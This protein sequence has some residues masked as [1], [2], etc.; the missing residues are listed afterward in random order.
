MQRSSFSILVLTFCVFV[1]AG[2]TGA[3]GPENSFFSLQPLSPIRESTP[4]QA[5]TLLLMVQNG[6]GQSLHLTPGV[7]LPAGWRLVLPPPHLDLAAGATQ[8]VFLNVS[9]PPSTPP[10]D[11]RVRVSYTADEPALPARETE[12]VVRVLPVAGLQLMLSDAPAFTLA[13]PFDATFSV[14]NS[15]NTTLKL[16]FEVEV[17]PR[18]PHTVSQE[19]L[20]LAAGA[21]ATVTVSV[22]PPAGWSQA[23]TVY[24]RLIA[25]SQTDPQVWA[26]ATASVEVI[27]GVIPAR[28]AYYTLPAVMELSAS[29][30]AKE[31]ALA[32][33]FALRGSGRAAG[34]TPV[35]LAFDLGDERQ[36]VRL[37]DDAYSLSLG[38]QTSFL[39]PLVG[40]PTSGAGVGLQATVGPVT[41]GL[42]ILKPGDGRSSGDESGREQAPR[43]DSRLTLRA[44]PH[45]DLSLNSSWLMTGSGQWSIEPHLQLADG[46]WVEWEYGHEFALGT[47]PPGAQRMELGYSGAALSARLQWQH[48]EAGYRGEEAASELWSIQAS[49]IFPGVSASASLTEERD[50]DRPGEKRNLSATLALSG[51]KEGGIWTLT[52]MR[53]QEKD[54]SVPKDEQSDTM[55]YTVGRNLVQG[56]I[57][58]SL[59]GKQV[60]NGITSE[61]LRS[62]QCD[63][64]Y[65]VPI[66]RGRITPYFGVETVLNGDE[67]PKLSFGL[68]LA[69]RLSNDLSVVIS[70]SV[71]DLFQGAAR[72]YGGLEYQLGQGRYVTVN[73]WY[74]WG[75]AGNDY[76]LKAGLG[77]PFEVPLGR[78]PD[79]GEVRGRIVDESGTGIP[80]LVVEINNGLKVATRKDGS[81]SFPAVPAGVVYLT[82]RP[83]QL[84]PEWL[85]LPAT[86]L[87]LEVRPGQVLKQLI[88]LVHAASVSGRVVVAGAPASAGESAAGLWGGVLPDPGIVA[89]MIVELHGYGQ[90][91]RRVIQGPDGEFRF[92]RLPPGEWSLVIQRNGL[93][94]TF[95]VEPATVNFS[96]RPGEQLSVSISVRPV[97]RPIIMLDEG[98][99]PSL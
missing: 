31:R 62:L 17:S 5:V 50:L 53:K 78:R 27:P 19:E 9:I 72:L 20:S 88:T 22:I 45:L 70:G 54:L 79:V 16:Q 2:A 40:R 29:A 41:L 73:G 6:S 87:R 47:R 15:G 85:T 1:A 59:S 23:R 58:H 48:R 93:P 38:D 8:L 55:R 18:L 69:A 39:S 99:L 75:P 65:T 83:D 12:F 86:P 91:L 90:V 33:H 74:S 94:D 96:L 46:W 4:P 67:K 76:S 35:Y 14:A 25:R 98:V 11:Y 80:G 49:G 77:I 28:S 68:Q 56:F 97:P 21:A 34:D 43:I 66:P 63:L 44:T 30:T 7:G 95:A 81:F 51:G 60:A 52:Y 42:A 64:Q 84:G 82:L 13:G 37:R 57:L 26:E 32:P 24:I 89:G 61:R 92:D 36:S 3:A 10:G 71:Q